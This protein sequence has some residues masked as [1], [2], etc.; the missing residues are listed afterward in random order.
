MNTLAQASGHRHTHM[1][2]CSQKCIHSTHARMHAYT[3][4]CAPAR[5]KGTPR[6]TTRSGV[7]GC[8]LSAA[9][10]RQSSGC[11]AAPHSSVPPAPPHPPPFPVR[12]THLA[13]ITYPNLPSALL[14]ARSSHPADMQ[15]TP[16]CMQ[17]TPG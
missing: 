15:L 5:R 9:A 6:S 14:P 1:D 17:L 3:H 11:A 10:A 8:H 16:C 12:S 7:A 4:A 13:H 2:T